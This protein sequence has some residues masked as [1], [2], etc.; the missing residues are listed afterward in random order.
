[1]AL[2]LALRLLRQ[3]Y[4]AIPS[5]RGW[6]VGRDAFV[7]RLLGRRALVVRG[8]EGARLF[9]DTDRVRREKAAPAALAA[10]LF[11]RGAVHGLDGREHAERKALMM[12]VLDPARVDELVRRAGADLDRAALAWSSQEQVVLFDELVRTYGGAV[13]AWAGTGLTDGDADRLSRELAR[14]VDGFGGAGAA[15][16]R[17]WSARRRSDRVLRAVLADAREG[18][19]SPPAG[20]AVR[21]L[22]DAVGPALPLEVAAVELG[23]VL[24][25]TV[26]VAWFGTFA[27]LALTENP[28]WA[29]RLASD[30]AVREAFAHEVRRFYPF[31]PALAGRFT[32]SYVRTGARLGRGDR[33]VLDVPGTDFDPRTYEHPEVFAP[34]RFLGEMPGPFAFV[35]QGGGHPETGHRCPGERVA[36]GMLT[37]TLRVLAGLDLTARSDVRVDAGRI[38]TRP[39]DGLV[40]QVRSRG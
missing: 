9:Y 23:N 27:A 7:T 14:I 29:A 21:L 18:R 6:P 17:A 4:D 13:Q 31:V 2:D 38:P 35:P 28:S 5:A 11:G 3:G 1:V 34:E 8:P 33:I 10:L 36:M 25:P 37:E 15:Y 30:A 32:G 22:A 19:T 20:S 39:T 26:A 16:P 24:R 40:L 12:R